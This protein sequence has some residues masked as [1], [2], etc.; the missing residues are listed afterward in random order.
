[1]PGTAVIVTAPL[2]RF[3]PPLRVS[4]MAEEVNVVRSIGSEKVTSTL[5]T[6]ALRGSGV[7]GTT[8]VMVGGVEISST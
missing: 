8:C 2:I 7:T 1:M 4:V 3:G 5:S 6:G